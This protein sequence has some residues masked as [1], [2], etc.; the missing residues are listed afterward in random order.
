MS[1]HSKITF[2]FWLN[3][4]GV[5][6]I[7]FLSGT[8]FGGHP[9]HFVCYFEKIIISQTFLIVKMDTH[10]KLNSL[11]YLLLNMAFVGTKMNAKN[12]DI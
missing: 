5:E 9:V 6:K 11:L 2:S 10:V 4:K 7:V 8:F 3:M 12:T 1:W